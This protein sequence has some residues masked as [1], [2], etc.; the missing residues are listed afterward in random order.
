MRKWGA[1][2]F[3]PL[4]PLAEKLFTFYK[5]FHS[6]KES[7]RID[8][9]HSIYFNLHFLHYPESQMCITRTNT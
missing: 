5:Y 6:L 3:R 9:R 8:F 2:T 7:L 4:W 1:K